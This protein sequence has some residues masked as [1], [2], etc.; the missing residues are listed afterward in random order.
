MTNEK[1]SGL[2]A[3]IL[4]ERA[5]QD[6]KWGVQDHAPEW[7]LAILTAELGEIGQALLNAERHG[8]ERWLAYYRGGLVQLAAVALAAGDAYDRAHTG[9]S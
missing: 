4:A 3:E 5:R 1:T 2:V 7:W 9:A 6:E 8:E